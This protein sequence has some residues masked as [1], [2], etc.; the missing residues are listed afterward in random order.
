ML[1][2]SFTSYGTPLIRYR[3]GDMW[4]LS[5]ETCSCG[6]CHPVVKYI[7]GRQVDYLISK[8]HGK[9]S[10]SHLADVI[11]GL[12]NSIINMQF[13]QNSEDSIEILLVVDKNLFNDKDKQ[14]IINEMTYRFGDDMEF[15][16]NLTDEIPKEKSGK[17]R[18]IKLG[19]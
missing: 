7:E 4:E 18:L 13:I 5:D 1:V 16:I 10:L 8:K 15:I 14:K 9:V 19:I 12:P 11:K 17:Y 6:C 3:I 2:T